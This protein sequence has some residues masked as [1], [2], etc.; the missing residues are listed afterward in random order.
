LRVFGFIQGAVDCFFHIFRNFNREYSKL[1]LL[2]THCCV[3]HRQ[4]LSEQERQC[5][6]LYCDAFSL[7]LLHGNATM[8]SLFIIGI[9][10]AD[11]SIKVL[12]FSCKCNNG[13]P[14]CCRRVKK[15]FRT[16][17]NTSKCFTHYKCI[18]ACHYLR[19]SYSARILHFPA[20]NCTV[21]YCVSGCTVFFRIFS[22]TV[23]LSENIS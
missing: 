22:Y 19:V 9:D 15:K 11:S 17:L 12:V 16:A 5:T 10:V 20:Q 21:A 18:S 23:L 3:K 14:L 4:V 8:R 1:R 13:F 6:S 7:P 2:Q